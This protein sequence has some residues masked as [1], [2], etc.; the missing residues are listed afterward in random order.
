MSKTVHVILAPIRNHAKL[1]PVARLDVDRQ[2]ILA[3]LL[4]DLHGC[5][6]PRIVGHVSECLEVLAPRLYDLWDAAGEVKNP[7]V[8]LA[9]LASYALTK[10]N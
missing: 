2:K 3:D 4:A 5:S 7:P 9:P 6:D 8:W 1:T 10:A